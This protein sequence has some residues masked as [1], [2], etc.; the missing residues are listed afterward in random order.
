M[1]AENSRNFLEMD[2]PQLEI[3][4]LIS[5][6]Y[7]YLAETQRLMAGSVRAKNWDKLVDVYNDLLN[8]TDE[9]VPTVSQYYINPQKYEINTLTTI[10]T[11]LHELKKRGVYGI[12]RAEVKL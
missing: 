5:E 6:C 8:R 11:Y 2:K 3:M 10:Q 9:I 1:E 4:G 12:G 7:H